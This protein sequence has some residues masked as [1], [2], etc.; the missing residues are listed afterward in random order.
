MMNN[1]FISKATGILPVCQYLSEIILKYGELCLVP[2]IIK[3]HYTLPGLIEISM[4][5][6]P[7]HFGLI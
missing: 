2:I 1:I 7:G 6:W 3:L 4:G 5:V